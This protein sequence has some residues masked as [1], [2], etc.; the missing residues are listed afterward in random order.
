MA[1]SRPVIRP[2]TGNQ[3]ILDQLDRALSEVI[4][5]RNTS[6]V[7][8]RR[9]LLNDLREAYHDVVTSGFEPSPSWRP[10]QAVALSL[11]QLRSG[12][13]LT[14]ATAVSGVDGARPYETLDPGWLQGLFD[15]VNS[16]RVNFHIHTGRTDA[17]HPINAPD[18]AE[19]RIA[20][21][22]DWGGAT[23][24]A[25]AVKKSIERH[26]PH[27]T[28]HLGD[29][30]YSGRREEEIHNLVQA[31]PPGS[32]GSFAL[33]SDHEMYSG[34][35]SYFNITLWSRKFTLQNN[36]SYFALYNPY[37]L[38]IG[39]DTAYFAYN[40]SLLYEQ[41]MLN[42]PQDPFQGSA[43]VQ[44]LRELLLEHPAKGV[45]VLTHHDGFEIDPLSGRVCPKPLWTQMTS[46][47]RGRRE[48][49]WYWG[50][51]HAG[52][53]YWPV[54]FPDGTRVRTRCAGHGALPSQPFSS[55]LH[56]MGD[57]KI[58]VEWAESERAPAPDTRRARNGYALL[59]LSGRS[60][61]E[62]FYDEAGSKRWSS[63]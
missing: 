63:P 53:V 22:G 8:Q 32:L 11:A 55:D 51:V 39:L 35:D 1:V 16:Q 24:A 61:T 13:T 49:W 6:T 60:I 14:A 23:S 48:W 5:F 46:E 62:E 9:N 54:V 29:V 57:T 36:L 56:R 50:H 26:H 43:Q 10:D 44:W 21:A 58:G 59:T 4:R 2:I 47:L 15:Y 3:L 38:I 30:Y 12:R 28:I 42:D 45:I 52:I 20:I 34:G 7:P 31:W 19:I 41:G 17:I 37:W 25:A 27:Y 33:N 40:Y 18:D